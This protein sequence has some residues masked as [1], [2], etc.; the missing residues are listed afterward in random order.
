MWNQAYYVNDTYF[1]IENESA[2]VFLC[3][4]TS[5]LSLPHL[6]VTQTNEQTNE[7]QVERVH[8]WT[9]L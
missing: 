5:S 7:Q 9:L 2:P 3:V 4:G 8:L 6:S 1:N